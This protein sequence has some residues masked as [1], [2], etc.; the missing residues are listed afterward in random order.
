MYWGLGRGIEGGDWKMEADGKVWERGRGADRILLKAFWRDGERNE[1]GVE[2]YEVYF[3]I[4][5]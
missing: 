5:R 3:D 2:G 1:K 4:G